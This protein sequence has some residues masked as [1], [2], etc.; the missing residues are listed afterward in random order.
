MQSDSIAVVDVG[1][2]G[3]RASTL[4]RRNRD[5]SLETV[6]NFIHHQ[7][8]P[9]LV[10]RQGHARRTLYWNPLT[11][12][13]GVAESLFTIAADSSK[14]LVSIGADGWGSD[15][16]WL[17]ER[18][19]L[20]FPVVAAYDERWIQAREELNRILPGRKRFELTG[21]YP[22]DFLVVNQIYWMNHFQKDIVDVADTYLPLPSLYHYWLS[23]ER[24]AEYT[25]TTTGQL[26][27]CFTQ[28]YCEE[29]LEA[30]GMPREK[31]PPLRATGGILGESPKILAKKFG[32]EQ[33]KVMIP[34]N[35]DTACA[36]AAAPLNQKK[37]TLVISAGTWWC[38]GTVLAEPL[39]SDA[40]YEARFSN[41]GG[42][43]KTAIINIINMGSYPAQELRK[44][45]Q[46][47]DGESVSWETFNQMAEAGSTPDM[48]FDID[49]TRLRV[50]ANIEEAVFTV[51]KL[52]RS[53]LAKPRET[54][55][56]LIYRGLAA[57]A[58]RTADTLGRI[59][60][61]PVEEILV[62]GGGANNDLLNQWVANASRLPVRTASPNATTLGNA[63]SQACS[64]GWFSSMAEGREAVK[65]LWE[66][67]IFEPKS[68]F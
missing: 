2:S 47:Q 10:D 45:W 56:A 18:G 35:H 30:T 33:F 23:G 7:H 61:K 42:V 31:L 36:Y 68:G 34:P 39:V 63:L 62:I 64:L 57:K 11:I 51:A 20:I 66:E 41:V 46:L 53:K 52:D 25:W 55:S 26:A 32:L 40:V 1:G 17:S 8:E 37:T 59:L 19:D 22:D 65:A 14:K 13:Q 54:A 12:Y 24:A 21:T 43:D 48:Q 38:M 5:F 9:F 60:G 27:S 16:C 4:T 3:C 15:G 67:K 49:D 58:A 28:A 6:R 44:L 50:P 29:V